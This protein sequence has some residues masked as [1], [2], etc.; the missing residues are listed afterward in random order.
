MNQD[1]L[2]FSQRSAIPL[3]DV[4]NGIGTNSKSIPEKANSFLQYNED[5]FLHS[6]WRCCE[7]IKLLNPELKETQLA[8]GNISWGVVFF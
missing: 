5:H 2:N 1:K 7:E 3:Q 8:I 6:N 4:E